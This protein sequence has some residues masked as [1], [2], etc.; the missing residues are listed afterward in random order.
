M[1][2]SRR[3][4]LLGSTA[5][6]ALIRPRHALA[7]MLTMF[8]GGGRGQTVPP[9]WAHVQGATKT[10]STGVTSDTLSFS[11]PITSGN[12]GKG[13]ILL[14]ASTLIGVT[15]DKGNPWDI[16]NGDGSLGG[17]NNSS[18]LYVA[19]F[20]SRNPITNGAKT[21]TFTFSA[22]SNTVWIVMDEFTAG[23]PLGSVSLDG[24]QLAVSSAALTSPPFQSLFTNDLQY[25]AAFCTA[26]ISAGAGWTAA[27]GN[28]T[29]QMSMWRQVASP[30]GNNVASYTYTPGNVWSTTFGT[31]N[32]PQSLWT[33]RQST[34]ERSANNVPANGSASITFPK[35]LAPGSIGI[36]AI[37]LGT[38]AAGDDSLA[39]LTSLIDD[40]GNV[41]SPLAPNGVG[42]AIIWTG[43]AVNNGP[44]TL[45]ATVNHSEVILYMLANEFVPP[46]GT[47]TFSVDAS[48]FSTSGS[49][50]PVSGPGVTTT[51]LSE[52]IYAFD[53]NFGASIPNNGFS[54]LNGQNMSWCDAYLNQATIGTV[55]P[56]WSGGTTVSSLATAAFKA[57]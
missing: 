51:S 30:S 53:D 1:I 39:N 16:V 37:A 33:P 35:A 25:C 47:S 12:I 34:I 21:L 54:T 45:T 9:T 5:A 29:Q 42:R 23:F 19:G 36:G 11:A 7:D 52:L 2:I 6:P 27:Q 22:A 44:S 48:A 17:S 10:S 20:R 24:T 3:K 50:S 57:S 4:F 14:Q 41:W 43:G 40:K 31:R 55:T 46:P 28:A 8:G 49:G 26:A 56:Q 13:G 18:N 15:D 38:A 32:A